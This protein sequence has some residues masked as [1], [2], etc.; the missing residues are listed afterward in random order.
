MMHA[1]TFLWILGLLTLVVS[2]IGIG[3]SLGVEIEIIQNMPQNTMFYFI[4]TGFLGLIGLFL[5]LSR[6]TF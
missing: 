3:I 4:G 2:L 1:K 5:G 6:K